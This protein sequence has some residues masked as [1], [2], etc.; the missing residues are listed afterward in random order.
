MPPLLFVTPNNIQYSYFIFLLHLCKNDLDRKTMS[1][2][3]SEN[4]MN[5]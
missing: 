2:K 1:G 5:F 3:D 4:K